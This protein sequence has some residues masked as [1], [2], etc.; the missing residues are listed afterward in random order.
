MNINILLR[1]N[2][3]LPKCWRWI[4]LSW[5]KKIQCVAN[6]VFNA[7]EIFT[8]RNFWANTTNRLWD[9]KKERKKLKNNMIKEFCLK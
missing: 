7:F 2:G 1:M 8:D 3:L 9:L 4:R 5:T 6:V